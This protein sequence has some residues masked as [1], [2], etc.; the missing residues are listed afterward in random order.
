MYGEKVAQK[1][2]STPSTHFRRKPAERQDEV[3]LGASIGGVF[4][5]IAVGLQI[6][7]VEER[8]SPDAGKRYPQCMDRAC[9]R[10]GL[11]TYGVAK[12]LFGI[13]DAQRLGIS[14]SDSLREREGAPF[15]LGVAPQARR[16]SQISRV[17]RRKI[18]GCGNK[19]LSF[20]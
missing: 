6:Q 17:L 9:E 20:A 10:N 12:V 5:N 8:V 2:E 1:A 7:R 4:D 18:A 11:L 3:D 14:V 15:P 19:G 16:H 13:G